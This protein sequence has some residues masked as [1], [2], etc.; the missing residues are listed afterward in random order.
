MNSRNYLVVSMLFLFLLAGLGFQ[1]TA[2][3]ATTNEAEKK[4]ASSSRIDLNS[5]T[6]EQ[7]KDLPGVGDATAQ[8]I[9][10]NRPYSSVKDLSKAGLTEK[11]IENLRVL[12]EVASA[13]TGLIDSLVNRTLRLFLNL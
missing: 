6:A 3:A 2:A 12:I 7:L 10:A 11:Q 1:S 9:I 4:A 13:R 8:K 5:A